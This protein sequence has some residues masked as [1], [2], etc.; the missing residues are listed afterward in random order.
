MRCWPTQLASRRA[1]PP[2]P[3][4]EPHVLPTE[5]ATDQP[6][7]SPFW[8]LLMALAEIAARVERR[9][10]EEHDAE[11]REKPAA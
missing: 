9:L 7:T 8:P 10:A 11:Y 4:P 6:Q 5:S 3:P 2:M 1:S